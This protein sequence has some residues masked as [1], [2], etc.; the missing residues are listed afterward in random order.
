[1]Y[2]R[3][4]RASKYDTTKTGMMAVGV[5]IKHFKVFGKENAR[6]LEGAG[7]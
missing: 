1:V 7:H 5:S 2:Y 3:E 6:P 4:V